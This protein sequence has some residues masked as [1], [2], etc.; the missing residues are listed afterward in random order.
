MWMREEQGESELNRAERADLSRLRL[1]QVT[2][3]RLVS[4]SVSSVL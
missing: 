3:G 2:L 4:N 1:E